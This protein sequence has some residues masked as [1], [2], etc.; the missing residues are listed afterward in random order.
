MRGGFGT[1]FWTLLGAL[2]IGA[3][4]AQAQTVAAL[5][6]ATPPVH[7]AGAATPIP[8][9]EAFCRTRPAECEVDVSEP[10]AIALTAKAWKAIVTVNREVNAAIKPLS[11]QE[12]WGVGDR[13]DL[14]EDGYGDCEDYQLLKR[15]RLVAAGLPA[16]A[17]RMTVVIDDENQGHAVL[18]VRTDRGDFV[19]DNKRNSVL[20]WHQTG[21]TYVKREGQDDRAWVSLG[22]STSP[23]VTA[24][25]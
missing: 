3:P 8:A 21:Y 9:W 14:A 24:G 22:R 5:P 19:L 10:A 20:P 6:S 12:H 4:G 23:V 13:W 25:R 15:R 7:A 16:R 11:D 17:L 18:M 1:G 2:L